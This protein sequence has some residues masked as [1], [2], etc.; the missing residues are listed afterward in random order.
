VQCIWGVQFPLR[1]FGLSEAE[2]I[3]PETARRRIE[4]DFKNG[5]ING[6]NITDSVLSANRPVTEQFVDV[7][8]KASKDERK[9]LL[10]AIPKGADGDDAKAVLAEVA[11]DIALANRN[12]GTGEFNSEGLEALDVF[13][14]AGGQLTQVFSSLNEAAAEF[15]GAGAVNDQ[16]GFNQI[17]QDNELK[18][19]VPL[20]L[21]GTYYDGLER[22]PRNH[23]RTVTQILIQGTNQKMMKGMR[24]EADDRGGDEMERRK[25]A[26]EDAIENYEETI[27]RPVAQAQANY[28]QARGSVQNITNQ[29][30][31]NNQNI[32]RVTGERT[33]ATAKLGNLV[34]QGAS[35]DARIEAQATIDRLDDELRNATRQVVTLN[36]QLTTAQND[37][38]TA[39]TAFDAAE[40]A[41][42]AF[43]RADDEATRLNRQ[44]RDFFRSGIPGGYSPTAGQQA[45][46]GQQSPGTP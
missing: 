31:V 10:K 15:Q 21:S 30:N 28:N 12:A 27:N 23:E 9:A 18:N 16:R 3:S 1:N 5:K 46:S 6:K 24:A 44:Y 22:D 34:A 43:V 4:Y 11:R 8:A 26:F 20:A 38:R 40:I 2:Q 13:M 39:R 19:H 41:R 45:S 33:A 7:L 35:P 32:T 29:I 37:E 14:R 25:F 42:R 17:M 36:P